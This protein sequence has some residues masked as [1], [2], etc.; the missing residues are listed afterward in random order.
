VRR[1]WFAA[2]VLGCGYPE[3]KYV[4]EPGV[5]PTEDSGDLDSTTDT[6]VPAC[7]KPNGCGGC[8][9]Q[10]VKGARCEPC[11][12]WT[13]GADNKVVCTPASPAPG[14]KCGMCGTSTVECTATGTT[15]CVLSDD[16]VVY[17]DANFKTRDDKLFTVDRTNE[18]VIVFKTLRS[19]AYFDISA[20]VHRIPY[21]CAH[22]D[23]LPHPDSACSDCKMA[24]AGGYDCTVPSPA[25]GLL[26]YTLYTGQPPSLVPLADGSIAAT[27]IS[28]SKTD[29]M[30]AT[31]MTPVTPRPVGTVLAIG[32]TTDSTAHA[33]EIYGGG[34]GSFPKADMATTW[35]HRQNKPKSGWNE[36]PSTD[37]AH[38]LRGKACA[39]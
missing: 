24:A 13:C 16:R 9:D 11:G 4:D 38:V 12:Q 2:L 36:E 21:V 39:P 22:I 1:L 7:A 17:D 6:D 34:P 10:G 37:V 35:W 25:A 31:L 8:D 20:V 3:Y 27:M 32:I 29:W 33:F 14:G 15:M 18:L 5:T 30:T 28:D 26:T 23:A 19:L